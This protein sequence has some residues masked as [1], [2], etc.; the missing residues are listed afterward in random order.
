MSI[1]RD[2]TGLI[3]ALFI[4]VIPGLDYKGVV[5][6]E[7]KIYLKIK[8]AMPQLTE[9][10]ILNHLIIT[11]VE[12]PPSVA[13]KE[14]EYA[15]Y[16]PILKRNSKSLE[17]VIWAIVEYEFILSREKELFQKLSTMGAS[18]QE[19]NSEIIKQKMVFRGYIKQRIN[20]HL[21]V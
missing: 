7:I 15:Y 21:A 14:E 1:L 19:F 13:K 4:K 3:Y 17:D 10:D 12:A 5:N 9:N 18:N 8:K 6:T 11:R 16:E 2:L 20:K